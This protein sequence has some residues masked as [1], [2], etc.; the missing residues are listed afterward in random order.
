MTVKDL[1]VKVT[2]R[3]GLG[4]VEMPKKV[5]K[6]ILKAAENSKELDPTMMDKQYQE[7]AN[8]LTENIKERD[9]MDW[10]VEI[11]DVS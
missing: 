11:E 9:C 8:W 2:Y 1:S 10:E 7:A 4:N 3:V 6:Q 5:Y